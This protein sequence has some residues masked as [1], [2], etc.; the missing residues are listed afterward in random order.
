[1]LAFH[2]SAS[3]GH[4]PQTYFRRG[5]VMPAP[6]GP[7][8]YRRLHAAAEAAGHE[9][10]ETPD[11]GLAPV[12]AV[13]DGRYLEFLENAWARRG[14]IDPAAEELLTTQ[15]ARM[16]MRRLSGALGNE[17]GYFTADTS[18][19]I[20]SD[21]WDAIYGGAQSAVSA[22]DAALE[23]GAAYALCRPPGHH[24]FADCAGGFCY[25]NNTAIAAERMRERAG[26]RVAIIDVDV[27]HG[28]G[29]QG[30]FYRRADI[31]TV[32]IH[33]DPTNYF[34]LYAGYAD[35][36]GEDAGEGCNLNLPLPHGAGDGEVLAALGVALKRVREFR[37]A[38]MVV[39]LG[40]D[41]AAADPLGV[42]EVTN[43]GF[44]SIAGRIADLGLPAALIQE[45]GYEAPALGD[46]LAA[47][48]AAFDARAPVES[49]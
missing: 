36:R 14:E 15:F 24:A 41:A 10:R 42:F 32:S 18:T 35:E 17:I 43:E 5:V 23:S 22:A 21:T 34:P 16:Q 1:M 8:R 28:N 25:L 40:L 49:G 46:N 39:A 13:H 33:A 38:A 26:D 4:A 47:F 12:R 6:E 7:A 37:P 30:I 2:S 48:L 29:T 3:A 11:H 9:L 45:G 27:H 31:L 44:A 20:R 19:P